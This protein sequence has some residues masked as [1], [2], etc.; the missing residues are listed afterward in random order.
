MK[1]IEGEVLTKLCLA[2][3]EFTE[4]YEEEILRSRRAGK[5]LTLGDAHRLDSTAE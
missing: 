1:E 5:L 4:D 2:G 3:P